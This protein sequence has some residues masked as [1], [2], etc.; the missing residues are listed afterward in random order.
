MA[1]SQDINEK[2]ITGDLD[3]N[4]ISN[5]PVEIVNHIVSFLPTKDAVR[6]TVLSTKWKNFWTCITRLHFDDKLIYWKNTKK[7]Y[8]I[9]FVNRVLLLATRDVDSV[10]L[11]L[12][13]NYTQEII[14]AWISDVLIR[15]VQK[16]HFYYDENVSLYSSNLF[17]H[18]YL[19]ELELRMGQCSFAVDSSDSIKNLQ[20]LKLSGITF[21]TNF[22]S[23]KQ[24]LVL[25]FRLLKIFEVEGCKWP[26]VRSVNIKAP[27]LESFSIEYPYKWGQSSDESSNPIFKIFSLSLEKLSYIVFLHDSEEIFVSKSASV[28]DVSFQLSAVNKDEMYQ[29]GVKACKFLQQFDRVERMKLGSRV[30]KV[31]AH[32]NDEM[33]SYLPIF[34][35]LVCLELGLYF[36][37]PS[38][39]VLLN[40]LHKS[41]ELRKLVFNAKAGDFDEDILMTTKEVPLC[42]LYSLKVVKLDMSH[43][44]EVGLHLAKYLLERSRVLELLIVNLSMLKGNDYEVNKVAE[45][46]G[47]Y[48]R[49]SRFLTI[50]A[51]FKEY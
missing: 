39:E 38:Q 43:C 47:S 50:E 49:A 29:K 7:G 16:F 5:L 6:T 28:R 46:L 22:A 30:V 37:L 35:R 26:D 10:T 8:F 2:Q 41:P 24:D 33:S 19:E 4:L 3:S 48:P 23:S 51:D 14:D 31:L 34:V 44:Y 17:N 1:S 9:N 40:L 27:L 15:R 13:H 32:A 42:L 25:I 11:I 18:K 45:A 21:Q 12:W 36:D 20:I